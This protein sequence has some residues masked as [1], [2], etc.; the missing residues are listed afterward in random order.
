[1]CLGC[2]SNKRILVKFEDGKKKEMSSYLLVFL[3]S[4]EEIDMDEPL[5]NSNEK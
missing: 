1:M 3:C 5:S 2:G 4:K